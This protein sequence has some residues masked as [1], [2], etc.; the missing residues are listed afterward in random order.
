MT[1]LGHC[2]FCNECL[3][4]RGLY[5]AAGG[6]EF[7]SPKAGDFLACRGCACV[8]VIEVDPNLR[9]R[10]PRPG[11]LQKFMQALNSAGI[12]DVC[13]AVPNLFPAN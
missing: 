6:P 2:P 5:C 11:E 13:V 9:V 1:F 12:A 8:L 3:D 4:T 10:A 7:R